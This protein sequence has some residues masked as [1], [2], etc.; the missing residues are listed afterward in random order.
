[1]ATTPAAATPGECTRESVLIEWTD[2]NIRNTT[3]EGSAREVLRIAL[4]RHIHPTGDLAFNPSARRGDADWRMLY[5]GSG[6]GGSGESRP[7]IRTNPQRLDTL[8]G[9]ILRIVPDLNEHQATSKTSANGRYRIPIDNPFVEIDGARP[10][11]WAVGLRNP[12]RLTWAVDP[13][14]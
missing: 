5:I 10:E 6:D 13:A 7:S 12:H 11:I 9:K 1:Y 2:T 8:V 14:D 3:F 4:N